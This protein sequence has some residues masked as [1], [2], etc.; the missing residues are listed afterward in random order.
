MGVEPGADGPTLRISEHMDGE[1]AYIKAAGAI[2]LNGEEALRRV[3]ES[4]IARGARSVI[5][6]LRRVSFMDAGA[7][8]VLMSA[9]SRVLSQG[10]EVYVLVAQEMP[11]RVIHMAQMQAAVKLCRSLDEA[12]TEIARRSLPGAPAPATEV[13]GNNGTR[14]AC[15]AP[16]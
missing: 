11:R 10:G 5:F 6:D 15:A 13:A 7:L 2:D 9:K 4:A 14:S 12:L 8:K 3:V 16:R 1:I